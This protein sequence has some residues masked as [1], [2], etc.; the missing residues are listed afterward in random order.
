MR[1]RVAVLA[2]AGVLACTGEPARPAVEY[3]P[4]TGGGRLPFSAAARVGSTLYLSGQ[5]GTDSTL[6]LVPG[7]IGPETRQTMENIRAIL[8]QSRATLDDVIRCTVMMADMKEWGDMNRVYAGF[9]SKHRPARSAFGATGLAL[10]AR[11]EIE[12]IAVVPPA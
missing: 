1:G 3:L 6:H 7:G 10:G 4:M 2:L 5:I 8:A 11:V 9:F 12:C